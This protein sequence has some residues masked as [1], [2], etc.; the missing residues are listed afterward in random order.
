MTIEHKNIT[1]AELHEPKG[2]FGASANNVYVSDGAAGGAWTPTITGLAGAAVDKV[3]VSDGAG[4]GSFKTA[5]SHGW[6]NHNDST[7]TGAP[8]A[9]TVAGTFYDLTNDSAGAQQEESY[10]L[11]TH[12]EIWNS[13]TGR[14]D[15]SGAGLSLGD[16]VDMRIDIDII[17]SGANGDFDLKLD[18][19]IGG[20]FPFSIDIERTY[21]KSP[22]TVNVSRWYSI[23]IGST[24]VL[25]NPA[26][27]SI[28]SDSTGD[29]VVVNGWYVRTM[30][31]SPLYV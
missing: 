30:L 6:E 29:T 19:A 26:K 14:F 25:N 4:G 1:D 11:P 8:I 22:G 13:T 15:W 12:N 17:N 21:I 10:R 23:Y 5:H 3:F 18:M 9:L 20:S 27:F 28:S 31:S 2:V 16:T 24:D 7:T